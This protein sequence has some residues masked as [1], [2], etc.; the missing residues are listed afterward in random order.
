VAEYNGIEPSNVVDA[1]GGAFGTGTVAN[2]GTVTTTYA[3]DLLLAAS[4]A[5]AAIAGAGSGFTPRLTT[6]IGSLV[7][8]ATVATAGPHNASVS[9][10]VSAGWIIQMVAFRDTNHA[11]TLTNP[12]GRTTAVNS[13]VSLALN[14]S[15][16]DSDV[17][18]FAAA[19][20]PLGLSINASTGVIS[21]TLLAGGAGLHTV[22]LT[23][24]DGALTA[25]Q[26][27]VWNV[28]NANG[29]TPA[30]R[31]D[32]FDGDGRTDLVV[33]RP[34]N[35]TWYILKSQFNFATQTSIAWGASTD[36]PAAGDYDGDGKPDLAV[37]RPSTGEW[38]ILY[39]G[40]GYATNTT[41]VWGT[42]GDLPVPGDYDGDGR[43]DIAVFHPA[44]RQWKIL[45]S[46]ANYSTVP[47]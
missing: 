12:G 20:L 8:D 27:I 35:G 33:Y 42:S 11:P 19:G 43:T 47:P 17:L 31:H 2:T 1:A 23:V 37:F 40:T 45:Y 28:T 44:T 7:E 38:K 10:S 22:T 30:L 3:K 4:F 32:D 9:L 39:S 26:S 46:T 5:P 24:S 18:T 41:V 13:S 25:T 15:D 14:A 6:P 34:G 29:T 16:S 36:I 21:G